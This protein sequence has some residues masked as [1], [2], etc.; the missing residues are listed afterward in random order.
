MNLSE[1]D[2]IKQLLAKAKIKPALKAA[3]ILVSKAFT[4]RLPELNA[5]ST[6][7]EAWL[8]DARKGVM[9]EETKI[10]Q[11]NKIADDLRSL[12]Q[13]I[14]EE[15]KDKKEPVKPVQRNSFFDDL[16]AGDIIKALWVLSFLVGLFFG[17]KESKEISGLNDAQKFLIEDVGF[18][19]NID[20]DEHTTASIRKELKNPYVLSQ[21]LE[22]GNTLYCKCVGFRT[23]GD[24]LYYH[25]TPAMT[26]HKVAI[27]KSATQ[28]FLT[29]GLGTMVGAQLKILFG[30][31]A[32]SKNRT[33]LIIVGGAIAVVGGYYLGYYLSYSDGV[34]CDNNHIQSIIKNK[35]FWNGLF[36]QKMNCI[37][38]RTPN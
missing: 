33:L 35:A 6:R 10:V 26:H 18:A 7:Y 19:F 13:D 32:A 21:G 12:I 22:G 8:S 29:L 17:W 31:V 34:E 15:V 24:N 25:Y 2:S 14:E 37:P 27:S 5:L 1:L 36:G 9:T 23:E 20:P 11:R 30:S 38:E 4:H 3:N 28:I 16:E